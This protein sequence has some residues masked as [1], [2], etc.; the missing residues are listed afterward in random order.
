MSDQLPLFGMWKDHTAHQEYRQ[1]RPY[2]HARRPG[3][4]LACGHVPLPQDGEYVQYPLSM[5]ALLAVVD[6]ESCKAWLRGKAA[7]RIVA[8][9]KHGVSNTPC[10]GGEE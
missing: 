10:N 5:R 9:A 6:C 4:A 3:G 1:I 7:A 8:R 2:R